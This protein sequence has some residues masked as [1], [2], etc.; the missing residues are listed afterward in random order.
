MITAFNEIGPYLKDGSSIKIYPDSGVDK[1][2][3]KNGKV[4]WES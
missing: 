3:V 4:E 1:A 2:V